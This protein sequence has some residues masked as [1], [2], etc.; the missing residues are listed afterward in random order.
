[1]GTVISLADR[2]AARATAQPDGARA[3]LPG[4]APLV[5]AP[6]TVFFDLA[7]PATYLMAERAERLLPGARWRPVLEDAV[8]GR[9][10]GGGMAGMAAAQHRAEALGMPL[11][12]PDR[13]PAGGRSATR[14]A[15]LAAERGRA[16]AFALAASRLQFCGGFDLDEPEILA[17]A[18]AAAGLGL[19]EALEAAREPSRDA[20]PEEEGR[21]LLRLGATALPAFRVGRTIFS[22]EGEL[23]AA[24]ASTGDLP[25]R[26]AFPSWGS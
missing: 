12:W 10:P 13:W 3:A 20:K 23:Q 21:R 7:S 5:R 25:R 22:G 11:C 4:G 19:E 16:S 26:L 8:T 2:R 17:E 14:V 1:M 18:A 24:V 6:A 15:T 9:P